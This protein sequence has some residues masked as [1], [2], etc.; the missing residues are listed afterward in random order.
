MDV[1]LLERIEKLGQMGDVV[2][3]K[4]GFARNYLLPQQK[5]LRATDGNKAM[6]ETQKAQLEAKNL[7]NRKEAEA[8]G[9]KMDGAKVIL[10]RQAGEAGQLYGSVNARDVA[11]ALTAAGFTVARSQVQLANPIKIL[12]LHDVIVRLHPEV[13]VTITANVARTEDEAQVQADTGQAVVGEDAQEAADAAV[14]AAGAEA[15]EA[16]T[17]EPVA[18]AEAEVEADDEDR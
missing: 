3:V 8:V 12:G 1:I 14:E 17:V 5:A 11:E 2:K 4:A 10:I 6:F 18:E 9:D 15:E 7:E 13:S 16:E